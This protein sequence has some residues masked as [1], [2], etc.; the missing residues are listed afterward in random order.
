MEKRTEIDGSRIAGSGR[1]EEMEQGVGEEI[2]GGST[3]KRERWG[4]G[5]GKRREER[6]QEMHVAKGEKD[7]SKN[8][9]GQKWRKGRQ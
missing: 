3:G 6:T 5:G 8:G 1:G 4:I 7:E 9:K 2:R